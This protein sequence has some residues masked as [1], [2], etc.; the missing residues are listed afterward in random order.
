MSDSASASLVSQVERLIFEFFDVSREEARQHASGL[1]LL[2]EGW[3]SPETAPSLDWPYI[4][5]KLLAEKLRWR[6][7]T[8]RESFAYDRQHGYDAYET[9]IRC[10]KRA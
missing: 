7:E 2:A 6:S 8:V 1:V 10:N 4:V 5:K 9:Y 3:G